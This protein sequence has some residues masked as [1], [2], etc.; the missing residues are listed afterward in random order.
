MEYVAEV[1]RRP[2]TYMYITRG[3]VCLCATCVSLSL[4]GRPDVLFVLLR[5]DDAH[6]AEKIKQ[7]YSYRRAASRRRV[8]ASQ[9]GKKTSGCEKALE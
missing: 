6:R 1:P 5:D 9:N 4:D 2:F 7:A 8:G 3:R